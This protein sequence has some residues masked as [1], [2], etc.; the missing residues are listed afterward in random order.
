ME[1]LFRAA[2]CGDLSTINRLIESG[3]DPSIKN[4]HAIQIAAYSNH[5]E[6]VNRL[7]FDKRVDPS[8]D[9]NSLIMLASHYG[10]LSTIEILLLDPRVDVCT[11]RD[12]CVEVAANKKHWDI[13]EKLLSDPRANTLHN[14]IYVIQRAI[15]DE[16]NDLVNRLFGN[17]STY[18]ITDLDIQF[19][20]IR[21]IRFR[22]ADIC[23]ALQDLE[24]PA[25]VTLTIIDALIPNTIKMY[26][27]WKLITLIK[28]FIK[29][30]TT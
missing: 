30:H 12:A 18:F 25:Y 1:E 7:L 5:V 19:T 8:V 22:C 26:N 28:H 10:N 15:N 9:N 17:P 20:H 16:Q 23:I 11:H 3:L 6:I 14:I 2:N 29:K 27:K 4:N 24:L 13:A 21:M